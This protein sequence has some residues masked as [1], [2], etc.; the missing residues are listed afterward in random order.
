MSFLQ[1]QQRRRTKEKG[2]KSSTWSPAD[3]SV[4]VTGKSS[5]NSY[6]LALTAKDGPQLGAWILNN[7]ESI[8]RDFRETKQTGD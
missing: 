2:A 6:T 1:G 7:L 8:Y 4:K 3:Q 5:G